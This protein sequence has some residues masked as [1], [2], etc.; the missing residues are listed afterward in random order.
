VT[1]GDITSA[2]NRPGAIWHSLTSSRRGSVLAALSLLLAFRVVYLLVCPMELIPDEAYYWD[3]SR[4]LDWSYYSKPPLIAWLIAFFTSI[5]GNSEFVIR[6][7][8]AIAGT[9][10]LWAVYEIGRR[11]YGH[12]TGVWSMLIIAACPGMTALCLFMTVVAPF[13]LAWSAAVYCLW[14]MTEPG[15]VDTRWIFLAIIAT[16][17]GLLAKQS[18]FGLFPLMF[19]FLASGREDRRMLKS[20]ALWL[21]LLGSL[22]SMLPVLLWNVSHGWITVAHTREHLD[23]RPVSALRHLTLYLE[24]AA[25]QFGILSP[26][27]AAL[28]V[29]V[30]VGLLMMIG[31]LQ[32]RERFLLCFGTI[33]LLAVTLLSFFQ[34]VQPNW[35]V[36]LHLTTVVGLAAWYC[37]DLSFPPAL[38]R[39]KKWL[40]V[41]TAFGAAM[42][43]VVA[44]IPIVVP[45]SPLSGT[46]LDPTGRLRGWRDLSEQVAEKL[47]TAG[48]SDD[49]IVIAATSRGPVSELA[50]YL[51]GRPRVYRWNVGEVVDSQHDVWGGPKDACGRDS[52]IVTD[53]PQIP[54]RLADAFLSVEDLGPVSVVIGHGKTRDFRVWRGCSLLT[55]PDNDASNSLVSYSSFL[56]PNQ[57]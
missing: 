15:A 34:R 37:G 24:F 53:V 8:A 17:A 32:R 51:P 27:V 39:W 42:S 43:L 10:G 50:Y 40:P 1:C 25:S 38:N 48:Q 41:S 6:L 4:Q 56:P 44:T 23:L 19:F 52:L 36:A 11:M 9:L 55:W 2:D 18:A 13:L 54:R 45:S 7:P 29:V 12:K 3:W 22:A 16:S 5:A 30:M 21:W 33:P 14:R 35:P 31:R 46:K 57:P 20:P 47:R 49:V 26:P 28:T